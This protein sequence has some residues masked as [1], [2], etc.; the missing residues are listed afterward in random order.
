VVVTHATPGEIVRKFFAYNSHRNS[1]ASNRSK[2][3][4]QSIAI[5]KEEHKEYL[6]D[7]CKRKMSRT[8]SESDLGTVQLV[9]VCKLDSFLKWIID[10]G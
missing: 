3:R 10:N 7:L 8:L 1:R 2:S 5:N 4:Q 6:E 9:V